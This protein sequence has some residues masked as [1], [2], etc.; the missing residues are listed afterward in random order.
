MQY[1]FLKKVK[2]IRLE[3]LTN[4]KRHTFFCVLLQILFSLKKMKAKFVIG[5]SKYVCGYCKIYENLT[6]NAIAIFKFISK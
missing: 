4:G 3:I 6:L 1:I 2:E 5:E